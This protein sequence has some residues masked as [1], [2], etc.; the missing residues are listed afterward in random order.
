MASKRWQVPVFLIAVVVVFVLGVAAGPQVNRALFRPAQAAT[1][2]AYGRDSIAD[3]AET[4]A[5][6]VVGVTA[7]RP[8]AN[9]SGSRDDDEY[10][11]RFFG[12]P[13]EE[14]PRE[15][16]AF[17]TG[18]IFRPDGYILTNAH[19]VEKAIRVEVLLQNER[20]P[21][22][23]EV[24]G[25]SP[26]LDLAVLK[27]S[28][29]R[30]LPVLALG[31]STKLR[32]GEWVVAI[33][34]PLGYDHTVTAG[35]ISATGRR[36]EVAGNTGQKPRVYEDLLQ[37]DAAIN[38]GNS[39]GPLLNIDGQV[40][41]INAVV[42]AI[43]QGIGFAIPIKSVRDALDELIATGRYSRP[44]LGVGVI[45]LALV[46]EAM[47][48]KYQVPSG[49]GAFIL[50]VYESGPADLAGLVTGDV[51]LA[52]DG[53]P[54]RGTDDLIAIVRSHKV[55]AKIGVKVNHRGK[56]LQFDLVLTGQPDE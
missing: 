19:V 3:I 6:A 45:D 34:N 4:A 43:G 37:T 22:P 55:G 50:K 39:G 52:L 40:I 10:F 8:A 36:V 1:T 48:K 32:P 17:G 25:L 42:S 41:G 49:D 44:W 9:K 20:T 51:I 15:R 27:V 46:D 53:K 12:L 13:P 24:V 18:F 29:K 21:L 16:K 30:S 28:A 35:V 54:I 33:G 2:P 23:A 31:D 11:Q 56:E 7:Y 14:E 38:P 26:L 5:P 47:R